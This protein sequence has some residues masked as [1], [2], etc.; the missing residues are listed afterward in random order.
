MSQTAIKGACATLSSALITIIGLGV[1]VNGA[2]AQPRE[3]ACEPPAAGEYLLFVITDTRQSQSLLR[4]S[5]PSK[6]KT[7]V[8]YYLDNIV[9]RVSGFNS[10]SD[11]QDW[12]RYIN[13]ITGLS[14]FVVE[15]TA[16]AEFVIDKPQ[17]ASR[18]PA[19]SQQRNRQEERKPQPRRE[20]LPAFNP[21]LLGR[22]YAVLVDY[23][24][25]PK[26]ATQLEQ[27]LGKQVG[28]VSFGQRPY[29][30]VLYSSNERNAI[31]T[32][33]LLSD[34]GFLVM[35]VDGN[36]VTLLRRQVENPR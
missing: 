14:A 12:V 15:P 19:P 16:A 29:L 10:L 34:R 31:N 20:S 5:L 35:L 21:R 7:T 17:T 22:G 25:D 8:C 36:R 33:R 11:A 32:F 1:G 26:I 27:L 23:G 13:D 24:N 4:Q 6:T 3:L 28:L 9:T 2:L 30:L 18:P